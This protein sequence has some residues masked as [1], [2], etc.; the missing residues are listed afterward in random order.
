MEEQPY[1]NPGFNAFQNCLDASSLTIQVG[2]SNRLN[3]S[4]LPIEC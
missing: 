3:V 1:E 2:Y 4:T